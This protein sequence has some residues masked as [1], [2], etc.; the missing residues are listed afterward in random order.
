[1]VELVK[2]QRWPVALNYQGYH[3]RVDLHGKGVTLEKTSHPHHH[4]SSS[5]P[6]IGFRESSART[7][8]GLDTSRCHIVRPLRTQLKLCLRVK[9]I[10]EMV[11]PYCHSPP[12]CHTNLLMSMTVGREAI[13]RLLHPAVSLQSGL[14]PTAMVMLA[15]FLC[16][17][18]YCLPLYLLLLLPD[19]LSS[20]KSSRFIG[21]YLE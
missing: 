19:P 20:S 1:M 2:L 11:L 3:L 17:T 4:H 15:L 7:I 14:L 8:T 18:L 12:T 5:S 6:A 21:A 16:H 10:T 9:T 13:C